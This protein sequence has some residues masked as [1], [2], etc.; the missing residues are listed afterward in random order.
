MSAY[1]IAH[2]T[3][4]DPDKL[5]EY[6]AIAG[7][8]IKAAGGELVSPGHVK[9][10]LAGTHSHQRAIIIR[11]DDADTARAWYNGDTYQSAIPIREQ[12]MD[13]VFIL[14]EDPPG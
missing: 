6:G 8:S 9:D 7:P 10:V 14:S 2:A 11:F 4:K 12:A 13:A 5:K 3:I 1:V